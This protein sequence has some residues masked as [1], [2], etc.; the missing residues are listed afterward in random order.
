MKTRTQTR[1][2]GASTL[3]PM[4]YCSLKV[5]WELRWKIWSQCMY[6]NPWSVGDTLLSIDEKS[7]QSANDLSFLSSI[8]ILWYLGKNCRSVGTVHIIDHWVSIRRLVSIVENSILQA[9]Y[10]RY[11][12]QSHLLEQIKINRQKVPHGPNTN[13][14]NSTCIVL[15][16]EYAVVRYSSNLQYE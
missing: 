8:E 6:C 15:V 7:M 14:Y 1:R 13:T 16:L 9:E 4:S 2:L 5:L 12:M 3:N 11:H 10:P